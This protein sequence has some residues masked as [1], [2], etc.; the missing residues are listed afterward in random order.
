MSPRSRRLCIP[1]HAEGPAAE[2]GP[3][4]YPKQHCKHHLCQ[5]SCALVLMFVVLCGWQGYTALHRAAADGMHQC[6][7]ILLD[8]GADKS[9][10]DEVLE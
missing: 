5:I 10:L 2:G 1:W 7:G 8:A 6:L 3:S 4:Q 9:I